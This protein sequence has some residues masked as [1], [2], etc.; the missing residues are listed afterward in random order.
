MSL[1]MNGRT[2]LIAKAAPGSGATDATMELL[3][4]QCTERLRA[5][6]VENPVLDARVLLAHALGS[7]TT[8]LVARPNFP[9]DAAACARAAGAIERRIAGEPV[10]RI[11]GRKEFWSR[12]FALSAA[13]LVPRPESETVVEAALAAKPDRKAALRVLDLGT[14]CGAL[15]AAILLERPNAFGIG[16]DRSVDAVAVAR[17]NVDALG[18]SA[19]ARFAC[20]DWGT[21]LAGIFDVVVCN[22]P[23]IST[24]SIPTLPREVREH[25]PVSALDGGADGLAAYRAIFSDLPRL[26]AP[27]GIAVLEF[28]EG[29]EHIVSKLARERGLTLNGTLHRDLGGRPRALVVSAAGP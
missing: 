27:A 21:A 28:G 10:A 3:R 17:V 29:Q 9:I 11:V 8:E 24:A 18:L 12:S 15:L 7:D 20:G 13:T 6:G 26:L 14:G 23:Y 25:D 1:R 19:R 22:P 2:A 16:V 5:A 4:R